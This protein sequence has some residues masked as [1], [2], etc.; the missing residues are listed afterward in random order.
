[1][2]LPLLQPRDSKSHQ[3][4]YKI[5]LGHVLKHVSKGLDTY[6]VLTATR[7]SLTHAQVAVT[8]V[9]SLGFPVMLINSVRHLAALQRMS[10]PITPVTFLVKTP[11]RSMLGPLALGSPSQGA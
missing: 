11:K 3:N 1:M 9:T 8:V 7:V 2:G 4:Y 10:R 5:P 6:G